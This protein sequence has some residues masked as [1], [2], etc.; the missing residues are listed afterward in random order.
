MNIELF[1][2]T[3]VLIIGFAMMTREKRQGSG[4]VR[5]RD[6]D[7]R[8]SKFYISQMFLMTLTKRS[9]NDKRPGPRPQNFTIA[10]D[11]RR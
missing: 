3:R 2:L 4:V 9:V 11:H 7:S 8:E 6:E 1:K 5:P 10:M